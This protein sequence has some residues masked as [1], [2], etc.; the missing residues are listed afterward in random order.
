[1]LVYTLKGKSTVCNGVAASN[2]TA[3]PEIPEPPPRVMEVIDS[4]NAAHDEACD[5]Y[6]QK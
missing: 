5:S 3:P 4:L 6:S 2:E 1:M